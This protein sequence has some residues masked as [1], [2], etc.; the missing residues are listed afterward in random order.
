MASDLEWAIGFWKERGKGYRRFRNY[1]DGEHPLLFATEKFRNTFGPLFREF[2]DNLCPTVV[3]VPSDRLRIDGWDGTGAADAQSLYDDPLGSLRRVFNQT[4]K[5]AACVGDS[6][7]LVWPDEN[8]DSDTEGDAQFWPHDADQMCVR[9]SEDNPNVIEVAAKQWITR[10]EH[11]RINLYYE[12]R[13]E[14]YITNR[15][16]Q[17]GAF[18]TTSK[19]WTTVDPAAGV[20][21]TDDGHYVNDMG[22]PVFHFG[23][24]ARIGEYGTSVLR[25]VIPLQ[26]TLN[27]SV[28]DMLVAMEFIAY[29]QR[30]AT[31][32][33]V[34]VSEETGKPIKPPFTPGVDRIWAAQEGVSFGE[35]AI[36][37]VTQ[38]VG[39]QESMRAEI[40]RVSG[41]PTHYLNLDA[42]I[43]TG[44]GLRVV[45]SRLVAS[46]QD[47][48]DAYQ[49]AVVR[50]V[51]FGLQINGK[52]SAKPAFKPVWADPN[53][54]NPMLDAE[55]QVVKQSVG[56]SKKQSLREMRYT[57]AEI[58]QM[59]DEVAAE[60]VLA[61]KA[62]LELA[63]QTGAQ[64]GLSGQPPAPGQ[65]KGTSGQPVGGPSTGQMA[66]QRNGSPGQASKPS[67]RQGQRRR[68]VP[69]P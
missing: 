22:M 51:N 28:C 5:D 32:L 7:V 9:Y 3:D 41:L 11:G 33:Q 52:G 37:E 18:P 19:G 26:D 35:F 23:K 6:Y 61:M 66:H 30:W 31:G 49:A 13:I 68:P 14:K 29:P 43:P 42:M 17:S 40:A 46:L 62:T 16:L 57:D 8:P 20:A 63:A 47:D 45:E 38:F 59:Q 15:K 67:P 53:P 34:E 56:V 69:T 54:H 39:V 36:G 65:V 50:C 44:E 64:G 12:D 27:K 48:Q 24:N 1:Y 58:K 60:G 25:D 21:T 55:I 4:F 10:T 2:S